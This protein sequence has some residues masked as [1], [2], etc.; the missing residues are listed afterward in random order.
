MEDRQRIAA[1][2]LFLIVTILLVF[3]IVSSSEPPS[4]PDP[5]S[6]WELLELRARV[7]TLEF[8]LHLLEARGSEYWHREKN[9]SRLVNY[10]SKL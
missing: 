5:E 6:S 9:Q 2:C 4:R 7:S 8:R 10:G 3:W 1:F